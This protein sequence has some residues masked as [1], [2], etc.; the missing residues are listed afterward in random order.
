MP[1][2]Y[3]SLPVACAVC[4]VAE[5]LQIVNIPFSNQLSLDLSPDIDGPWP[6]IPLQYD[7]SEESQSLH[8]YLTFANA[9]LLVRPQ[10]CG[11]VVSNGTLLCDDFAFPEFYRGSAPGKEEPLEMGNWTPWDNISL[12]GEGGRDFSEF[13]PL[14]GSASGL[15][16]SSNIAGISVKSPAVVAGNITTVISNVSDSVPVLN[17]ML[18]L[19]R[20]AAGI[21]ES[22]K[23]S[24]A[25]SSLRM[26]S[27][28]PLVN[29]SLMIG[30]YD[31]NMVLGDVMGFTQRY[32]RYYGLTGDGLALTH[33]KLG[34]EHGFLPLEQLK[35]TN[36]S[37]PQGPYAR[38][39]SVLVSGYNASDN[40]ILI[41][42]GS[43]YM[44]LSKTICDPL[45]EILDLKYDTTRNIY[46]WSYP[47]DHPIF[48]S[49]AY[50]ELTLTNNEGYTLAVTEH[51]EDY[52]KV[53]IKIPIALLQP[54]F[55]ATT[56]ATN[57]SLA[58]P[59]RYFPCSPS[60]LDY[61]SGYTN[62]PRL[63]RAFLQSA[64]LAS[65]FTYD[66]SNNTIANYWL[67]QA[68]GPTSPNDDEQKL[69]EVPS[70]SIPNR[71]NVELEANAWTKSW[72]GALPIWTLDRD[73]VTTLDQLNAMVPG[74]KEDHKALKVAV[75][76]V[77]AIVI[78]LGL[79]FGVKGILTSRA[80][81]KRVRR[82]IAEEDATAREIERLL[83]SDTEKELQPVSQASH[84][85]EEP[86]GRQNS[87]ISSLS[88]TEPRTSN[89]EV[90]SLL[91][92][93][94]DFSDSRL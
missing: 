85:D 65:S 60:D 45:A 9:S 8:T 41:E 55:H 93:D 51:T 82:E 27:V 63:G 11:D 1:L 59:A 69:I 38:E 31:D 81:R 35:L 53:L 91:G 92:A 76:V 58:A 88:G 54:T 86:P 44:H 39:P 56:R 3:R 20:I 26:G 61:P 87:V 42:P 80:K 22:G 7:G 46:L 68:P 10:S 72:G 29:G 84:D 66:E 50:L 19:P 16:F 2:R 18:S 30:G 14:G 62:W 64:F 43:P 24:S 23:A 74:G 33:V 75:P 13:M 25:F 21:S 90:V 83:E 40:Y 37:F 6:T 78:G 17:S 70:G 47:S 48:R 15:E 28:D 94:E 49:P 67:A 32:E 52:M 89:C 77:G 36:L 12:T 73:G 34:V 5:A 4:A 71:T 57:G 79:F